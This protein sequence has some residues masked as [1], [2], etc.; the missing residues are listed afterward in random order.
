MD[1]SP[2]NLDS[3]LWLTSPAFHVTYSA[4]K[5]NRSGDSIQPWR[6]P[7]PIWNQVC[8]SISGSN[9]HFLTWIKVSQEADKVVWYSYLFKNFPQFVVIHTVKDFSIVNE[10]EIEVFFFLN[11]SGFLHDPENVDNLIS[12]SPAFSK[13]DL[14]TW[15][16]SVHVLLK[17]I[18]K[19][20]KNDLSSMWNEL[21]VWYFEH[22]LALPIFGIGMKTDFFQSCGHCWIFQICQCIE[23]STFTVSFSAWSSSAGIP[24]PP[25]VLLIVM[26]PKAHLTL[27]DI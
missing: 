12:G 14:Y 24:P 13:S 8:F 2:S 10:A 15:K 6:I 7:F 1:I 20:F 17:S 9:C 22:S 4:Y 5:L 27:Q 19:D 16:F 11:F 23:C 18:L 26:V 3:S 21:N 25:L